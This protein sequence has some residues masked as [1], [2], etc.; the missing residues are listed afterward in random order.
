MFDQNFDFWQKIRFLAK[1]LIF[2]KK[3]DFWQNI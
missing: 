2:G 3:L 1:H